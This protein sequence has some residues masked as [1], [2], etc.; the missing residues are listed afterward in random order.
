L[1]SVANGGAAPG[2][3]GEAPLALVVDFDGTI[4]VE[5]TLSSLVE[6]FGDSAL[7]ASAVEELGRGRT[8]REVI[9]IGYGSLKA[10][11]HEIR[12]WLLRH[13]LFRRGFS[14]LVALARDRGWRIIVVSSGLRELIEPLLERE[15]ID[16][17]ELYCN[18]LSGPGWEVRFRNEV[19]CPVCGE[20]CKRSLVTELVATSRV[21]Y[22]GDGYSDGCGALAAHRVF[23]RRRLV[24]Y[25]DQRGAA[26]EPFEDFF[27]VIAALERSGRS[28][29]RRDRHQLTSFEHERNRATRG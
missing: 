24:E 15:G 21:I 29:D 5:E 14:E 19:A 25:L 11:R 28:D 20:A 22:V 7:H 4:T 23:A 10:S 13:V 1:R 16:G 12:E 17:V 2:S 27:D 6:Q 8:L 18:S 3:G 9:A 26:Y